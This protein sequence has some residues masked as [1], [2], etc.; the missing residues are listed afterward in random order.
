MSHPAGSYLITITLQTHIVR[1]IKVCYPCM[2][3]Q[4]AI[5]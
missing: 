2:Q 5:Q 3:V 1:W 4:S